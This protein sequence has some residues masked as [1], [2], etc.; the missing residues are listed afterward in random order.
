MV[1]FKFLCLRHCKVP[2][3]LCF[4]VVRRSFSLSVRL[5][6]RPFVRPFVRVLTL[7]AQNDTNEP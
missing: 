3:A 2:E 7:V 1:Y 4:R 5:F 6:V